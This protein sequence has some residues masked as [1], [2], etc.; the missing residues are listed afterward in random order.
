M[1]GRVHRPGEGK[2]SVFDLKIFYL[3]LLQD[4]WQPARWRRIEGSSLSSKVVGEIDR[5]PIGLW[6]FMFFLTSRQFFLHEIVV[7]LVAFSL[8]FDGLVH[9]L[10]P[11]PRGVIFKASGLSG[12]PGLL[13]QFFH[14]AMIQTTRVTRENNSK[15]N[16]TMPGWWFWTFLIFPNVLTNEWL[17]D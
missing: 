2:V 11:Y 7:L 14:L 6:M 3:A 10:P 17:V 4:G 13:E 15:T 5:F 16:Q 9:I 1:K 12:I 8:W